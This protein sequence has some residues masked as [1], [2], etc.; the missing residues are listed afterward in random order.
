MYAASVAQTYMLIDATAVQ[1]QG[2]GSADNLP[3]AIDFRVVAYN[4]PKE[5]P[6]ITQKIDNT[7]G[8]GS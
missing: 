2:S 6:E 4:R 1:H 3:R 7:N 5:Y 8:S